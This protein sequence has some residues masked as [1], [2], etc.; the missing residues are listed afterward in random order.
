MSPD[1]NLFPKLPRHLE[2]VRLSLRCPQVGD[3][4]E[5]NAAV[6]ESLSELQPW[7]EWAMETPTVEASEAYMQYVAGRVAAQ[8]E[9]TWLLFLKEK[10]ALIGVVSFHNFDWSVPKLMMSFWVRTPYARQGYMTE[11]A[12]KLVDFA[13]ETLGICRVEIW[14]DSRNDRSVA[15]A[16]RLDFEHEGTLRHDFRDHLTNELA[17]QMIFAKLRPGP[18]Q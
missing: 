1:K 18:Q 15:L 13:F 8:E 6:I 16:R 10:P 14:C 5:F 4:A 9:L 2:T 17:D 7:F 12:Q 11:G 3:G